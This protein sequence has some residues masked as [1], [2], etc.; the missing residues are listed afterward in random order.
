M[1]K[2]RIP[3]RL[4]PFQ[5][6]PWKALYLSYNLAT[7]FLLHPWWILKRLF[8]IHDSFPHSWTLLE[9]IHVQQ[10]RHVE[11][12]LAACDWAPGVRDYRVLPKERGEETRPVWIEKA[13]EEYL[14]GILD[15]R[16]AGAVDVPA[17]M[18]GSAAESDLAAA[19]PRA[20]LALVPSLH[21]GLTVN[22][23]NVTQ[24]PFPA[25]VIDCL[26]AYLYLLRRVKPSQIVVGGDSAGGSLALTLTRYIRDGIK[27]PELLPRALV[28]FSPLASRE[29]DDGQK[30]ELLPPKNLQRDLLDLKVIN[31]YMA[32]R[33][34][35]TNPFSLIDSPWLS[36]A[37]SVV[38]AEPGLFA[39]FPPTFIT[40]GGAEVLLEGI[41]ELERRMSLSG[42]QVVFHLEEDAPHDF[43]GF[44]WY[45]KE[46]RA[47]VFAKL[48][49][50]VEAQL[51]M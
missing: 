26:S 51:A 11:K 28:L 17:F 6:Q 35:M 29:T 46:V 13:G 15:S 37:S 7:L 27:R 18:F 25:A 30:R 24:A 44:S 1:S 19:N 36:P 40:A 31:P 23:R 4:S 2:P 32:T 39:N 34:L 48:A 42:V 22:Y 50:W 20:L 9:V 49:A 41:V 14:T 21:H 16:L 43:Q 12:T 45:K 8:H 10:L 3:L 33:L 47:V 5:D 38:P